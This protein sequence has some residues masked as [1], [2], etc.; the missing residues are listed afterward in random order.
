MK[1]KCVMPH[2]CISAEM[3]FMSQWRVDD[4]QPSPSYQPW[5]QAGLPLVLHVSLLNTPYPPFSS[6]MNE[7]FSVFHYWKML[8]VIHSGLESMKLLAHYRS[9]GKSE[10]TNHGW[11]ASFSTLS[12]ETWKITAE[13]DAKVSKITLSKLWGTFYWSFYLLFIWVDFTAPEMECNWW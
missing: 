10:S 12:Q 7:E 2:V 3:G 13:I 8:S 9:N 11:K 5:W 1:N 4:V 6:T